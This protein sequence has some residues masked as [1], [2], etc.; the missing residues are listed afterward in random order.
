M[1]EQKDFGLRPSAGVSSAVLVFMFVVILV[2]FW[3]GGNVVGSAKTGHVWPA[4]DSTKVQLPA[5]NL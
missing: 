5:S 2:I 4:A 3:Q 1:S